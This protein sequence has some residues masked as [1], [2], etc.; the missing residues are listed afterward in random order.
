M[1]HE[2][3]T[4][5][6][7]LGIAVSIYSPSGQPIPA[8]SCTPGEL[9]ITHPHPSVPLYFL[10]GT[11][12]HDKFV[13]AYFRSFPPGHE[14]A[15]VWRHDDV[16]IRNP[17]TGGFVVRDGVLN[18]SGVQFES[19]EIYKLV[20]SSSSA[21]EWSLWGVRPADEPLKEGERH[22]EGYGYDNS[23]IQSHQPE[24]PL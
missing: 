23:P 4:S 6:P 5:R 2:N 15:P 14:G 20:K 19:T 12:T 21:F 22:C 11:P 17:A 16:V 9:V 24:N 8:S 1:I 18:P 10:N 7:G 13:S 3:R